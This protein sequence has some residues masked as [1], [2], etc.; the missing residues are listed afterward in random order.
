MKSRVDLTEESYAVVEEML[1]KW[2]H[3]GN[4]MEYVGERI[5]PLSIG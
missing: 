1:K 4:S 5:N 3:W 2:L